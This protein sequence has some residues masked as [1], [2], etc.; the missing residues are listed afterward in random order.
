MGSNNRH[1]STKPFRILIADDDA[2]DIEFARTSF[3][4]NNLPV[5]VNDVEDGQLLMDHLRK[6]AKEQNLQALPQLIIMDIN[7][8]RKDGFEALKEIKED[9]DFCRIPVVVLS[10]SSSSKDIEKAYELG[11]NC[12]VTKPKTATD[13]AR[14]MGDL[15]R[16]WIQCATWSI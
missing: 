16:F 15:G 2:E 10:T 6:K 13:W 4:E 9:N 8:P 14:T 1:L 7:M 3:E 5:E 11:A 12:Y